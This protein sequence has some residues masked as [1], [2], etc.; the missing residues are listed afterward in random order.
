MLK[1]SELK[2]ISKGQTCFIPNQDWYFDGHCL[3]HR[4]LLPRD[5]NPGMKEYFINFLKAPE[6]NILSHE[7]N[8]DEFIEK[9]DTDTPEVLHKTPW[10]HESSLGLKRLYRSDDGKEL[11]IDEKYVQALS[12]PEL[13]T[14][15]I[16]QEPLWNSNRTFF[17]MPIIEEDYTYY[18]EEAA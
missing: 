16:G 18:E 2:R 10:L 17:C 6:H 1:M 5:F 7:K 4:V 13:Y 14:R 3:I 15:N 11:F 8:M 9:Y 12:I